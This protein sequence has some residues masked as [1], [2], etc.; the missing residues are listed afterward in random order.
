[1]KPIFAYHD[2]A[3]DYRLRNRRE[4]ESARAKE[5]ERVHFKRF[6][7]GRKH[8]TDLAAEFGK[9]RINVNC[10]FGAAAFRF[11]FGRV[12]IRKRPR[13]TRETGDVCEYQVNMVKP[14]IARL[15]I[16]GGRRLDS[17]DKNTD[18]H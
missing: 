4:R 9:R 8:L 2:P 15:S 16:T 17:S 12:R 14:R 7:R 18:E 6:R 11:A 5:R 1:M 13:W 10:V 3:I